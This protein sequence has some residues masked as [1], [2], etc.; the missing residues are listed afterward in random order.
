MLNL[1]FLIASGAA[2]AGTW[3]LWSDPRLSNIVL[4]VVLAMLA[5]WLIFLLVFFLT[6]LQMRRFAAR[7]PVEPGDSR[8]LG[9]RGS[10]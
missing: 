4:D 3:K 7:T 9:A 5:S 10:S 1:K 2:A 8:R 6:A